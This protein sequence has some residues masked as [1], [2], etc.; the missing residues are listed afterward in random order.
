MRNKKIIVPACVLATSFLSACGNNLPAEKT[1]N[2]NNDHTEKYQ[3]EDSKFTNLEVIPDKCI[4]CGKCFRIAPANFAP[5]PQTGKSIVISE[6]NLDSSA[7]KNAEIIC[8]TKA[9]I[10]S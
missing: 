4:A 8:P 6:K 3:K 9:I 5:D 2:Q 10:L 7:V 1:D